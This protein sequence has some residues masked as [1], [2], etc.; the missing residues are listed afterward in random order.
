MPESAQPVDDGQ[1]IPTVGQWSSDKHYYLSRYL[2]AFTTSMRKKWNS[3]HYIDLFAGAGIERLEE[4]KVLE[5]GSPILACE[6]VFLS[7][8]FTYARRAGLNTRRSRHGFC[9]SDQIR[10]SFAEM[11]TNA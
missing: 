9:R 5:W 7:L 11:P 3:L 10:K 6:C 2:D 4:S 8:A 1:Y